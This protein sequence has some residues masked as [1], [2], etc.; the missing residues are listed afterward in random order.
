MGSQSPGVS[1]R[2]TADLSYLN[3]FCKR[4]T[5]SAEAPFPLARCIPGKTWKTVTDAWNGY[6]CVP[7]RESDRH[8]TTFITPW[9]MDVYPRTPGLSFIRGRVQSAV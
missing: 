8:L 6:H 2:R 9:K 4:E 3:R 5:F 7:L 1:H